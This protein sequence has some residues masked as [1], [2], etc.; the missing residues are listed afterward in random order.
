MQGKA[1]SSAESPQRMVDL[2]KPAKSREKNNHWV[3]ATEVGIKVK[4]WIQN[5]KK[6]NFWNGGD[7]SAEASWRASAAS[8]GF[9]DTEIIDSISVDPPQLCKKADAA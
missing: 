4:F 1:K 8:W 7:H 2:K 6:K 9:R 3:T 5:W